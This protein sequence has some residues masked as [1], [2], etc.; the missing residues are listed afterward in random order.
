M[1]YKTTNVKHEYEITTCLVG[2]FVRLV[3]LF[4]LV[5]VL[6]SLLFY[7]ILVASHAVRYCGNDAIDFIGHILNLNKIFALFVRVQD[8]VVGQT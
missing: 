8:R 5:F 6:L 3:T 2:V 4:L 7:I 1:A